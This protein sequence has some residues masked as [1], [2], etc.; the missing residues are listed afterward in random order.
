[1][2]VAGKLAASQVVLVAGLLGREWAFYLPERLWQYRLLSISHS[3]FS[4]R[5]DEVVQHLYKWVKK[6]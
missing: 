5:S 1:M 2:V 6:E 3:E 4:L